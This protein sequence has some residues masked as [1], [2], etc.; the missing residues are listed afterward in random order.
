LRHQVL[1]LLRERNP[2]LLTT[3]GRTAESLRRDSEYLDAETEKLLSTVQ[4]GEDSVSCSA[5][6]LLEQP[7]A[8][9]LRL[10]DAMARELRPETV[11]SNPQRERILQLCR[12]ER[13]GASCPLGGGLTARRVYDTLELSTQLEQTEEAPVRL[14]AGE[15]VRF[16]GRE[17]SCEEAVCPAGKF[18]RPW[19]YYLRPVEELLLRSPHPGE[20]ITL[21][22]R[23]RK[24]VKRLLSE[25]KVPLHLRDRVIA[26]EAEGQL[27]ALDGFG[28]DHSFM[29][30]SGQLCWKITSC[31]VEEIEHSHHHKKERD[32]GTGK[33]Y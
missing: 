15:S 12:S 31:P 30:S 16:W 32:Y 8:L 5:A 28:A 27:A 18:N 14:R 33:G 4:R 21:P 26:L 7:E 25:S 17:L 29:P 23:P 11:L 3:L 13:P 6:A 1:P 24:A 22:G 9:S 20:H 2:R 19:E 10:V